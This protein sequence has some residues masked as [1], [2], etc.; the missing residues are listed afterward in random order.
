[1]QQVHHSRHEELRVSTSTVYPTRLLPDG[2]PLHNRLLAALPAVDYA[3]IK[4]YLHMN[5]G[6]TGR[7]LQAHGAPVTDVYFPNGGVFSVTN[8]MRDGA[9]TLTARHDA[10]RT[11]ECDCLGSSLAHLSSS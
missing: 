8:Q 3:R 2:T 11:C 5:A 6:A 10:E 4:K 1:V 9:I 7:T